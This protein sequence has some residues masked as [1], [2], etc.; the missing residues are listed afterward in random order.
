MSPKLGRVLP[1]GALQ[2]VC[3]VWDQS[4]SANVAA[5]RLT[6][7]YTLATTFAAHVLQEMG[8]SCSPQAAGR[9]CLNATHYASN[10]SVGH[11]A[12]VA[13]KV[14]KAVEVAVESGGGLQDRLETGTFGNTKNGQIERRGCW[15][16][17]ED[18]INLK[19]VCGETEI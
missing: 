3:N 10:A 1:L 13:L 11:E 6:L 14:V 12:G 9:S 16:S 8:Q 15:H 5:H 19:M 18:L 7:A 2:E 4:T 17:R